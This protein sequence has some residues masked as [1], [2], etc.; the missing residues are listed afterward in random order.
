MDGLGCSPFL[1]SGSV[2]VVAV[3][4]VAAVVVDLLFIVALIVCGGLCLVLVMLFITLCPSFAIILM[5][6][7]C[8]SLY[9]NCLDDL[10]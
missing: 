2:V 1:G 5:I 8:S 4:V 7:E 10:L 9:F 3:V 6:R